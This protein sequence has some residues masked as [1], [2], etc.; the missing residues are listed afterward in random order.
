MRTFALAGARCT[1]MRPKTCAGASDLVSAERTLL[2]PSRWVRR[3]RPAPAAV[4]SGFTGLTCHASDTDGWK[5][6]FDQSETQ[7]C[8]S[9]T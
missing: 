5:R 7:L 8:F 2:Q 3:A 4:V 1:G 6:L 9:R